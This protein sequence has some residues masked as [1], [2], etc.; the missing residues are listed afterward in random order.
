MTFLW[1]KISRIE[2][3]VDL[4]TKAFG[5]VCIFMSKLDDAIT[6]LQ[7][8]VTALTSANQSAIALISGI[9]TQ[10][11]AGIAAAQAAGASDAQLQALSDLSTAIEAQTAAL[12]A[13]VTANTPAAP[14]Q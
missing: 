5:K 7:S 4:L 8:D 13:A 2:R 9:N 14:A 3:N 6:K 11:Q 1:T 12:S 10:L